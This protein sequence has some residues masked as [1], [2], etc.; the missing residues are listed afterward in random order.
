MTIAEYREHNQKTLEQRIK[1]WADAKFG[2]MVHYGIY[3]CYGRGEWIKMRE[4]ISDEE[5][6]AT[7]NTQ[8]TYKAGTAEEWVKC[9]KRAGA[10]YMV[11]TTQH[12]DGF[13]LWDSKVNNF[14]SVNYGP[15]TDIIREYVDACRKYDMRVGFYFSLWNWNH[16]DGMICEHDEAARVRF[17]QYV[18]NEVRELMTNYGKIDV[19]WYDVAS[20]L[21]TAEEWESMRRNQMVRELQPDI[22]INERSLIDED[23]KISE[24]HATPTDKYW[25]ACMRF[26][27]IAFGGLD[28]K[29]A[30]PYK[31]NAHDI[32]KLLSRC[33]FL[34]GNLLFNITPNADGSLEKYETD[35]LN[36]VGAWMRKHKEAVYGYTL[37]GNSGANGICTSTRRGNVV[38]LWNWTW[39]GSSMRINGYKN[40]P[41]QV[42]ILSTGENV[43]F[44]Y[45]NG[46][47]YFDNLPEKCS[48]DILNIPVFKMDFGEEEP[49]YKLIPKNA[50]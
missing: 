29:N 32:V 46:V 1:W 50:V 40:A 17:I 12:H 25:E 7:L 36:T 43:D 35:T 39:P 42:S 28:H 47:L 20:P 16:P 27:N 19:L 11:V 45:E 23:F 22:L 4:G 8:F 38:Y 24:D 41:Q 6:T 31:M 34:G 9:A 15:K 14:N 5:Y 18:D 30:L 37:A 2:I 10:K 33:Q 49:V 21:K 3:S 44:R 48:E 26:S 13:A